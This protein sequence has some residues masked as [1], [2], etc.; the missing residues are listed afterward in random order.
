MQ[1]NNPRSPSE[2]MRMAEEL[3][4]QLIVMPET[5]KDT[6]MTKLKQENP[7]M[8]ALVKNVLRQ[9]RDKSK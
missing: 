9:M 2:L 7:T 1:P 8:H 3:A 6:E 4:M 5:D